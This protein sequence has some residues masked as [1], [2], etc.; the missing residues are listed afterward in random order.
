MRKI[1]HEVTRKN[2]KTDAPRIT[3][4]SRIGTVE[5]TE[6]RGG[7]EL[8]LTAG[9]HR[10]ERPTIRRSIQSISRRGYRAVIARYR[11]LGITPV[12]ALSA[13]AAP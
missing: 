12:S 13:P 3:R 5:K 9:V 8:D 10:G 11:Y 4:M 6:D 7:N 1:R 2:L